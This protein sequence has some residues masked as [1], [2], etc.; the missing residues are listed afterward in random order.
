MAKTPQQFVNKYIGTTCDYDKSHGP[1]CVDLF[2]I[3][4]SWTGIPV[5][6][7]P[8]NYADGYWYARQALG[9]SNYFDFI[10]GAQ[11][12]QNGDWVIWA[13][14]SKSHPDSHIAMWYEGREFGMN[15]GGNR[16][17]CV[18]QTNFN[19]A[20]GAL[21]YKPWNDKKEEGGGTMPMTMNGIDISNHQG[22]AG[23]DISKVYF[24]FAIMKSTEGIGFVDKYCDRWVQYCIQNDKAWGFYHFARPTNDPEKEAEYW[25]ENTKNYFGHGLPILDVEINNSNVVQWV[26][27]FVKK[28]KELSGITP[29]I[30]TYKNFVDSYDWTPVVDMDCGLWIACY[31]SKKWIYNYDIGNAGPKPTQK[32]WPFYAMWQYTSTGHIEGYNGNLDCNIFY[33]DREVWEKYVGSTKPD[34][35][36]TGDKDEE[37]VKPTPEPTP[38]PTPEPE[39]DSGKIN[40]KQKL[41]SRKF[42]A[43]M[44]GLI[45][46][47]L[48]M[49]GIVPDESMI[50]A[51]LLALG[52]IIAY[53]LGESWIDATRTIGGD[54]Q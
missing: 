45:I 1:Q 30:Y 11:N 19:D 40:W 3:F 44:A 53:I 14:G 34:V 37:P 15:Q 48:K 7:T 27:R 13:I 29:M 33:G 35:P 6:A 5:K 12:F 43:L 10:T 18:K 32:Y 52:S 25:Y 20:L 47:T 2:K 42:W 8:N 17:A 54:K 41:T 36:G 51:E 31:N 24:D 26:E 46:A 50:N 16:S 49:F 39:P 22:T 9:Y 38:D 21:R 23:F 4:C 28:I